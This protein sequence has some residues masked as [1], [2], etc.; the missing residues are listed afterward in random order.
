MLNDILH[1]ACDLL[2]G[3][4]MERKIYKIIFLTLVY[5]ISG[6]LVSTREG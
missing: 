5:P 4:S 2:V 3:V 6:N 1:V